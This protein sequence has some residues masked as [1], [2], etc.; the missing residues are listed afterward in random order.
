MAGTVSMECFFVV[1]LFHYDHLITGKK[2]SPQVNLMN[3]STGK[4]RAHQAQ[5]QYLHASP[6][7]TDRKEYLRKTSLILTKLPN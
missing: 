1:P 4:N 7:S 6:G 3:C 2:Q 5:Y